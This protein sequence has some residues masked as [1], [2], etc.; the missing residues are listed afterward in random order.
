[1]KT[2]LL[3]IAALA[4]NVHGQAVSSSSKHAPHHYVSQKFGLMMKVP[5]GLSFCPLPS[6][7]S[8]LEEGTVLF[9]KPPSGCLDVKADSSTTR[10][11][12][13]FTPSI[14]VY[15]RGN[16]SKYDPFDG[17]IPA[18]T[19]TEELARQYCPDFFVSPDLKLFDQPAVTCRFELHSNKVRI[20]LMSLFDSASNAL[21]VSLLTTKDRLE[22]DRRVLAKVSASITACKG[23]SGKEKAG[24]AACP[25]T[26]VW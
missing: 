17:R 9:L 26:A 14:T 2:V 6:E 18:S 19:T 24:M 1:M 15:Y 16:V 3:L 22:T 13:R 21:M 4:G 7:W 8:G 25:N 11:T 23:L 5:S 12:S 20:V 10:P